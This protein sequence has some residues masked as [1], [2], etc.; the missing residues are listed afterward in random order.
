MHYSKPVPG[1]EISP[2][3]VATRD[4]WIL[5]DGQRVARIEGYTGAPL[6]EGQ[7]FESDPGA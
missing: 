5:V 6:S 1:T 4:G 7:T 2:P 3:P